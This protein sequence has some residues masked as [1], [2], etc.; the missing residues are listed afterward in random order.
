METVTSRLDGAATG[1]AAVVAAGFF[2]G[3]HLGHRAVAEGALADAR[4]RGCAAWLFTFAR[5][6]LSVL[7]PEA[8][9]PLLST[10]ARRLRFFEGLG[11]DG[12]CIV[13][14]D[15]GLAA[16]EPDGFAERLLAVF[17]RLES[18]HCGG[19]WRFGRDGAG[20]PAALAAQGRARGFSVDVVPDVIVGG[21]PVSSTRI[22]AA[23]AEGD[24]ASAAGMLGRPFSVEGAVTHGR[25]VG[26]ANGFPTAN[27]ATDGLA[28]PKPGVYEVSVTAGGGRFKGIADI[29]WRPTFADDA[30]D[31]PA[32][33][34]HLLDFAG[35]LY[36]RTIEVEFARRLRDE[37]RFPS[38]EA[39]FAQIRRDVEAVKR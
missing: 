18:L 11:F 9:P 32:L 35:D 25:R 21:E 37:M 24:L 31:S 3:F 27:V 29:G 36:G 15:R 6:P 1:A 33:E 34:V 39:L 17:P 28:L 19:N 20:T 22:R 38:K 13:E 4:R 12:A 8:A 2:D 26:S 23:L 10:P 14:F 7:K 5:H 30:P 16:I